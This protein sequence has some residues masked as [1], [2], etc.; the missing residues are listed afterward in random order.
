[1]ANDKIKG[2]TMKISTLS[3]KKRNE[4]VQTALKILSMKHREPNLSLI[5]I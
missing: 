3:E 5:H 1:M 4:I 2:V